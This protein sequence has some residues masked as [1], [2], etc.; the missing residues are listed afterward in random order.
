MAR[1]YIRVH[2]LRWPI[3]RPILAVSSFRRLLLFFNFRPIGTVRGEKECRMRG[4]RRG[5]RE[6]KGGN[7][8][9]DEDDSRHGASRTRYRTPRRAYGFS[10]RNA[11]VSVNFSRRA[12][13]GAR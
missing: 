8:A 6:K 5:R 10:R 1:Y 9:F 12:P 4:S 3:D 7:L 2:S 11:S 13:F